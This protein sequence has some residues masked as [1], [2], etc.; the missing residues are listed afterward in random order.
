M[1][2]PFTRLKGFEKRLPVRTGR[3]DYSRVSIDLVAKV[4]ELD[5]NNFSH[6]GFGVVIYLQGLSL[7]VQPQPTG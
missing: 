2:L 6:D 3:R 7:P 5:Q 1:W 4:L